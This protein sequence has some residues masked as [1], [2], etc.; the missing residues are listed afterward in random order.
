[1]KRLL[2]TALLLAATPAFAQPAAAPV[3]APARIGTFTKL[4]VSLP[5]SSR[6]SMRWA[7]TPASQIGRE[8]LEFYQNRYPG[9]TEA[10]PPRMTGKSG[11]VMALHMR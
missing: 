10:K 11:R 6:I 8:F 3:T 4:A 1:M 2:A 9:L 5:C 7:T